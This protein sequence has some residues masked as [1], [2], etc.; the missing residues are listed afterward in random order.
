MESV[1][2]FTVDVAFLWRPL[3]WNVRTFIVAGVVRQVRAVPVFDVGGTGEAG[4]ASIDV[5]RRPAASRT[6]LTS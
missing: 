4:D 3:R 5:V 2:E 1:N 6:K